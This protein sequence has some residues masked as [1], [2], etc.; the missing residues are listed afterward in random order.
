M[1]PRRLVCLA[2][3]LAVALVSPRAEAQRL[4][5]APKRP[6]APELSDTNDARVYFDWGVKVAADAPE[7]AASAF[8]WAA[9]IDPAFGD[10][11]YARRIA[12]LMRDEGLLRA[13]MRDDKPSKQMQALDSLLLRAIVLNP[14]LYR[15]LDL[16]LFRSYYYQAV[17]RSIRMS[18]GSGSGAPSRGEIDYYITQQLAD[19]GP[20]MRGWNAYAM[21][22]FDAALRWYADAMKRTKEKTG[23]HLERG[24]VFAMVGRADSALAE[25]R[26][27]L[28]DL[29]KRDEKD[30]VFLYNSKAVIEQ[31]IGKLL[32][33]QND[34]AGA[35]EA[36]GRALQEDLAYWPAHLQLAQLAMGAK[37]TTAAVSEIALATQIAGDEPYVRS[38]AGA[39]L[40]M[41]GKP[42]DAIVELKKAAE[43]EPYYALPHVLLGQAYEAEKDYASAAAA[44][45]AFLARAGQRD[46]QRAFATQHRDALRARGGTE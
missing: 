29:R 15:R 14:F 18:G 43:L 11:L 16:Q 31:S 35:R 26:I 32:E 37:D 33:Q 28:D 25:L 44:Y 39:W 10:A 12:L 41:L 3:A 4:G 19:A 8:Y 5:P 27:A 23:Y 45:D 42:K 7:N 24:R 38:M 2:A 1:R 9:R 36:Y 17:E 20:Y 6:R 13:Y 30:V 40:A 21:G 22:D 46:A 34:V